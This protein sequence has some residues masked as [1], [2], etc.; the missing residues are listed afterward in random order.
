MKVF[1]IPFEILL[2]NYETLLKFNK[3]RRR[4]I[5]KSSSGV[6]MGIRFLKLRIKIITTR[7]E[8]KV[9]G[10]ARFCR[11][12]DTRLCGGGWLMVVG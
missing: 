11:K 2:V 10:N 7:D 1:T 4:I 6:V 3:K 5:F 9:K 12:I 8:E